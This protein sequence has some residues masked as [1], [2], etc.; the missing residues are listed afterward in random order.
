M[1]TLPE[2]AGLADAEAHARAALAIVEDPS[3]TPSTARVHISAGW[4]ALERAADDDRADAVDRNALRRETQRLFAAVR[5]AQ[6]EHGETPA[7]DGRRRLARFAGLAAVIVVPAVTALALTMPPFREGPWR[8]AFFATKDRT[9]P[10][11]V[12]RDGDVRY[13]W[14]G[15]RPMAGYPKDRFS[16]QWDTCLVLP[17]SLE[18]AFRLTSDDGARLLIDGERAV[19]N[20]GLH[21]SRTRGERVALDA[22][23][24]HLRVLYFDEHQDASIALTASFYGERP[25]AI[26]ARLL[27]YPGATLDADDPCGAVHG[28]RE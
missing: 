26:P 11:I 25:E 15:G 16:V 13:N 7:R 8:A 24:H 20:W 19:D 4:Q 3:T 6:S 22:G 5:S 14:A 2:L 27:R 23:V 12:R 10:A 28:V 9:G 21:G 17:E 1:S 18:V